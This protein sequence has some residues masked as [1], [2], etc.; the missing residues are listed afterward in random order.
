M[1][2][3]PISGGTQGRIAM[4]VKPRR[5]S[6]R[7]EKTF[8]PDIDRIVTSWKANQKRDARVSK[9]LKSSTKVSSDLLKL[10]M[11]I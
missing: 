9:C 10:K 2:A 3:P 7:G 1:G 4:A 6:R 5:S 11:T 8:E